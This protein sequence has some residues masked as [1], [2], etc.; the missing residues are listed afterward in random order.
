MKHSFLRIV[1]LFQ[2]LRVVE[3]LFRN[4]WLVFLWFHKVLVVFFV[5]S[6]LVALLFY[7]NCCFME[8]FLYSGFELTRFILM[9]RGAMMSMGV[10]MMMP[11]M[12]VMAIIMVIMRTVMVLAHWVKSRVG[13]RPWP[14][15]S[16]Q[17]YSG[18]VRRMGR[19][20]GM[21]WWM[22]TTPMISMTT[23][24]IPGRAWS[25]SWPFRTCTRSWPRFCLCCCRSL[26]FFDLTCP[27]RSN[28]HNLHR[29]SICSLF[30]Y[31]LTMLCRIVNGG[32]FFASSGIWLV[33]VFCDFATKLISLWMIIQ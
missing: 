31:I 30:F 29:R 17:R 32:T 33:F 15:S 2:R 12:M 26:H 10:M 4:I 18:G 22:M 16:A 20:R 5:H 24:R 1:F 7:T 21:S 11:T 13:S 28:Q 25:W 3:L 23:A 27:A 19:V 14:M 6:M 8:F 9:M